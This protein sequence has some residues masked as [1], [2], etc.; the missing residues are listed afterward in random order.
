MGQG[1][2]GNWKISKIS[3]ISKLKTDMWSSV[4][5]P[6]LSLDY[7]GCSLQT[8]ISK[9]LNVSVDE[10]YF[11]IRVRVFQTL[12]QNFQTLDQA[13]TEKVKSSAACLCYNTAHFVPI[14]HGNVM[15]E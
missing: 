6:V 2:R 3:K 12:E 9:I 5:S 1:K 11:K 15:L 14:S 10:I 13:F 7:V 4:K 8:I